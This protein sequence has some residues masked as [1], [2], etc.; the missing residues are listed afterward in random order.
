MKLW[1]LRKVV[2]TARHSSITPGRALGG[3]TATEPRMKSTHVIYRQ[4]FLFK[5][6]CGDRDW[7][8]ESMVMD[9][10]FF[11]VGSCIVRHN[12]RW[13]ERGEDRESGIETASF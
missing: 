2:L 5:N 3:L 1:S 10:F 6:N 4:C 8:R 7:D 12:E 9:F 11:A 13:K